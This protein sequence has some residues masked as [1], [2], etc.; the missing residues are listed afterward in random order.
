MCLR[1]AL[2]RANEKK[3]SFKK[4]KITRLHRKCGVL[5]ENVD[6]L[7]KRRH[8]YSFRRKNALLGNRWPLRAGRATT[9]GANNGKGTFAP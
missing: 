6:F 8:I 5:R 2:G 1:R 7:K 3:N 4:I 9:L